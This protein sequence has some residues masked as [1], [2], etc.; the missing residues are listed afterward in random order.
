MS[1]VQNPKT[2]I[3]LLLNDAPGHREIAVAIQAAW[4]EIGLNVTI[5]QQEWAQFLEF[6]GPP[7]DKSVDVYRLGWIGDYVDA[8]NFLELW[9][10]ESGNNSTNFCNQR[11]D[12]LVEQA[13]E[14]PDDGARYEIYAQLEEILHGEEGE[15]P[16]L[17]I[18]WYTYTNLERPSIQDS[19][20]LNLLDQVDLTQVEV[21][22]S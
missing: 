7:P 10:C 3:N 18:Y 9:T 21:T 16:T 12:Q 2:D 8:Y 5:R 11:Y 1:Q 22:E 14:T 6:I 4:K 13:R 19:F 17:P 15:M 20:N